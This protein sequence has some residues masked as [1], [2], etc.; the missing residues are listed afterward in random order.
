MI[1]KTEKLQIN[2]TSYPFAR[3]ALKCNFESEGYIEDEYLIYG[4]ANIYE[5]DNEEKPKVFFED[6]PYVNRLLVRRPEDYRKFSGRVVIEILNATALI[7]L[8]RIWVNSWKYFMRHGDIYIGITSKP[9]VVPA[10]KKFDPVRYGKIS[11]K[12]PVPQRGIPQ[13]PL[14]FPM[15]PETETGL[16]WD[17]LTD[18]NKLLRSGPFTEMIND[19]SQAILQS[20]VNN[21]IAGYAKPKIY[22]A[23]WSQSVGY[24][25]RMLK[26]F[27]DCFFDG[28][29]H[30]GAGTGIAPI[31]IYDYPRYYKSSE[32]RNRFFYNDQSSSIGASV[33]YIAVNTESENMDV[34][35]GPDSDEP[36]YLL[37]V[38]EIAGA[39]HD[40][41][42]NLLDYYK[43]D[44]DTEKI[45]M[46]PAYRGMDIFPNDYPS[47]VVFNAALELLYRWSDGIIPPHGDRISKDGN[48]I[49][50]TDA[51][52]NAIGGIRTP[53]INYPVARYCNYSTLKDGRRNTL[54]GHVEKYSSAFLKELYM[55]L[56]H[57]KQLITKDAVRL[58]AQGFLLKEDVQ[59]LI[60][61]LVQRA[62]EQGLEV[63]YGD[64]C[65]N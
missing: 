57:Y 65:S 60:D 55:D 15:D 46:T 8:D 36:G 19:G 2:K 13:N 16:F 34:N 27:P 35:W 22:L 51:F 53:A 64:R 61:L 5:S 37:R 3:A 41:K 12:N 42:Y 14:S 54:F 38:Y 58:E 31:N 4:T 48:R 6:A 23:A 21:P 52:G 62:K 56:D 28:Y 47:E 11:W 20:E 59:P 30:A 39:T 10:L 29:F 45:G 26:S 63:K 50:Y 7:D 17:M 33:P 32:G 49:N 40:S 44:K 43:D 24:L 18:L 9:D 25:I 1:Q